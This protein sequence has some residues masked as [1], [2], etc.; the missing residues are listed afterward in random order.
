MGKKD[1][2]VRLPTIG[3]LTD[4]AQKFVKR[5]FTGYIEDADDLEGFESKMKEKLSTE[6]MKTYGQTENIKTLVER[7]IEKNKT[8]QTLYAT[9]FPETVMAEIERQGSVNNTSHKKAYQL[10]RLRDESTENMEAWELR[11]FRS[12]IERLDP[13]ITDRAENPKKG[14][15][16][17]QKILEDIEDER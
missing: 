17:T 9:F 8:T 5:N 12:L 3:Q 14:L 1:L 10:L 6:L 15:G 2:G 11:K 7:D 16:K 4:E 13:L